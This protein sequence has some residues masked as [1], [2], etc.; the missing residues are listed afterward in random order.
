[1]P[2][3]SVD[4]LELSRI[5]APLDEHQRERVLGRATRR[6]LAR[7]EVLERQGEPARTFYVVTAGYLK[8]TQLTAGGDEVVVRFVGP[9]E[10]YGGVVAFGQQTYP[11]TAQAVQ[12]VELLAWPR[13]VLQTVLDD[14]PE[15]RTGIM[16][17]I[18]DHMR[19]ALTRVQQL[20]TERVGQRLAGTLL[21]LARPTGQTLRIAHPVT[22]Q[23]LAEMTGTTLF[24]VSRTL[25]DWESRG[26]ITTVDGRIHITA[27][28]RLA[29]LRDDPA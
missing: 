5:F 26:F 6:T 16:A 13:D 8:L 14:V 7:R 29:A 12:H 23:E 9:G 28:A 3:P 25:A 15:V 19:E 10:P 24:T 22:R 21:H 4:W 18:T 27:P 2:E 1:M 17:E 20:S 11:V